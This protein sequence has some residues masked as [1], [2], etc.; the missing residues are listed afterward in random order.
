[1]PPTAEQET[2][3]GDTL[4]ALRPLV[5]WDE[6]DYGSLVE[7]FVETVAKHHQVSTHDASMGD[8]RFLIRVGDAVVR[9]R[10]EVAHNPFNRASSIDEE[11]F[12]NERLARLVI[13]SYAEIGEPNLARGLV[14]E[15]G[16]E[17]HRMQA[18]AAIM[19]V[20]GEYQDGESLVLAA[21]EIGEDGI[22]TADAI[23][24]A[25][26][27]AAAACKANPENQRIVFRIAYVLWERREWGASVRTAIKGFK[28]N[29]SD[30]TAR[31][32]LTELIER[33]PLKLEGMVAWGHALSLK[34]DSQE[35]I[36]PDT[37]FELTKKS[38]YYRK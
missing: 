37:L 11:N 19:E 4:E 32:E 34:G 6:E 31:K 26:D 29:P 8:A 16:S 14:R 23:E 3:T 35:L 5:K 21:K 30:A 24:T 28:A 25:A 13:P 10:E 17:V 15:L 38:V 2:R 1:M 22:L 20:T 36:H 33:Q 27:A 7:R 18:F 9:I 12:E